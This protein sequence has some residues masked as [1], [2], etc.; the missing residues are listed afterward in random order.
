MFYI[1][2]LVEP[3]FLAVGAEFRVVVQAFGAFPVFRHWRV[4]C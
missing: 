1:G 2:H 3:G 4:F